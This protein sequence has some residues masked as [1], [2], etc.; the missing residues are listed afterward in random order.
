MGTWTSCRQHN[1]S[2]NSNR[3]ETIQLFDKNHFHYVE[4]PL[5]KE[6]LLDAMVGKL[7]AD[8]YTQ[9][10]SAPVKQT[11]SKME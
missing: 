3:S 8:H 4:H 9:L 5:T 7:V 6:K 10:H 1:H 2:E 11:S